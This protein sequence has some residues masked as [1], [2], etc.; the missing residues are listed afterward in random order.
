MEISVKYRM[1]LIKSLLFKCLN[2]INLIDFM[3]SFESSWIFARSSDKLKKILRKQQSI[4]KWKYYEGHPICNIYV[5]RTLSSDLAI[6]S[7]A[8]MSFLEMHKNVISYSSDYLSE[9]IQ[10]MRSHTH[11]HMHSHTHARTCSRAH[12]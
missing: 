6:K 5:Q 2:I 4:F 9:E 7:T 12:T 10:H 11:I 8:S 3:I 1:H